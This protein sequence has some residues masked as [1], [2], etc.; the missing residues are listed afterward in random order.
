MCTQG[1]MEFVERRCAQLDL[2][3]KRVLEVGAYDVNGSV[4]GA[5]SRWQPSEY[6]GVDVVPG[7]GVDLTCDVTNLARR[8]GECS[9]DVVISTEM[10]EH[11]RDWR[12]AVANLKA[13]LRPGGDLLLT[14]R[15]RGFHFHGYPADFW[16]FEISDMK[17]IF[18]DMSLLALES[19]RAESPGVLVHAQ[20]G[21]D[22]HPANIASHR[23][24]SV[25]RRRRIDHAT[26][27]DAA[28]SR[29]MAS[30]RGFATRSLPPPVMDAVRTGRQALLGKPMTVPSQ[31]S[32]LDNKTTSS[33]ANGL[34][35]NLDGADEPRPV[36]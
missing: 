8:L 5:V 19:D 10:L 4:R 1:C 31:R 35:R 24:Y 20:R 18:E 7:P 14:T 33:S 17:V 9:F 25:V 28:M 27:A 13:V 34:S 36:P 29:G 32:G 16:R 3:G 12:S 6:V 11:V 2:S 30:M 15:S 22:Y 23:V 26:V 21:I